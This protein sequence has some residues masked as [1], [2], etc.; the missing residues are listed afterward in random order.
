MRA[1]TKYECCN[2]RIPLTTK[3]RKNEQHLLWP[4]Q[5]PHHLVGNAASPP[6]H[7]DCTISKVWRNLSF[8]ASFDLA[9]DVIGYDLCFVLQVSLSAVIDM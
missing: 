5:W 8:A 4:R 6:P 3:Q 7:G 2:K 1:A 9:I